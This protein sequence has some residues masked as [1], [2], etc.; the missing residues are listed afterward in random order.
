MQIN[1]STRDLRAFVALVE[2]RSFTRAAAQCS[3]SQPAFSALIRA[4]EDSVGAKLFHRDTRNVE[5]TTEGRVFE[6]S[7]RR[8]L[9]D[10]DAAFED[11]RR[12]ATLR[13]GRVA[14]ALLPSLA[15]HWLPAV[16]AEFRALHPGIEVDVADVLSEPCIARVR[17]GSADFALAA[18]RVETPELQ[19]EPFCD[20]HFFVVCRRDHPLAALR[21]VLVKDLAAHPFIHMAR[22]TSV[23]Q[24]LDAALQPQTV[25][26][27]MEVEQ[28]AT[29]NGM[30]RAGLGVSVVPSLTLFYFQHDEIVTRPL[31]APGMTRQMFLIRRRDHG[32][33]SAAQAFHALVMRRRPRGAGRSRAAP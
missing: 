24:W 15:A 13:T 27:V 11:V 17:A 5:P 9:S 16:L 12:L 23:R 28:L 14:I 31:A 26:S 4:I 32:L 1:L 25:D 30:V 10:F 19:A 3:L 21:R 20:D 18:S 6:V 29:V 8:L 33:S 22:S 2:H 7:A